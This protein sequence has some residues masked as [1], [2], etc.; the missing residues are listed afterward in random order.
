MR[1]KKF[2]WAT[3]SCLVFVPS[4]KAGL[5]SD[6]LSKCLVSATTD[7]DRSD[8]IKWMFGLASLHP[9]V[10]NISSMNPGQRTELSRVTAALFE[11]L[12]TQDCRK[13]AVEA[14]KYEGPVA[15]QVSFQVLGQVAMGGLMSHPLVGKGMAEME[16]FLDKEKL[17][18]L[19]PARN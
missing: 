5:Y 13:Q 8:L 10:A 18:A 2:L 19:A 16:Q 12:V 7:R 6:E 4:A 14:I 17:E 1:V 15:M 9:D 11:R 3:V